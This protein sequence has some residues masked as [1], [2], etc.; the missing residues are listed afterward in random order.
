MHVFHWVAEQT[1][2]KPL[3]SNQIEIRNDREG[4]IYNDFDNEDPF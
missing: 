2:N 3:F 1:A 4:A